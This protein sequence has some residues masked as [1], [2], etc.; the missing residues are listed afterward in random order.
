[1]TLYN[2]IQ[3]AKYCNLIGWSSA[4]ELNYIVVCPR[5]EE[6]QVKLYG[7]LYSTRAY[8]Q[9]VGF[10]GNIVPRRGDIERWE[11][12][13]TDQL[14]DEDVGTEEYK[15]PDTQDIFGRPE[16]HDITKPQFRE[17]TFSGL[18]GSER[19]RT[20]Q[21]YQKPGTVCSSIDG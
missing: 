2:S 7:H 4:T 11:T 5:C 10:Q 20:T 13:R 15:A 9:A 3:S 6:Q 16:K 14:L 17:I 18:L 12:R 19:T 8:Q 21:L 1:M